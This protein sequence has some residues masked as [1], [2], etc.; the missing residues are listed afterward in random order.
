L[1]KELNL[2]K[3]EHSELQ[4]SFEM[5]QEYM[6]SVKN[7]EVTEREQLIMREKLAAR[8]VEYERKEKALVSKEA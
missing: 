1:K 2:L 3:R 8:G 5:M 7:I 4:N 6:D